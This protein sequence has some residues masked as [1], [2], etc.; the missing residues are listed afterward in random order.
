MTIISSQLNIPIRSTHYLNVLENPMDWFRVFNDGFMAHYETT[1]KLDWGLYVP[2]KNQMAPAGRG[3]LLS[4]SRLLVIS[5]AGVIHKDNDKPFACGNTLG[6]Y[7]I[8]LIPSD[9]VVEEL[10][11][12]E[13]CIPGDKDLFDINTLLPLPHL[14]AMVQ[15]GLVGSIAPVVISYCSHQPH[16]IRTVKEMIPVV[17]LAIRNYKAQ[18]VLILPI[19]WLGVQIAALLSR[20]IEANGTSSVLICSNDEIVKSIAPPRYLVTGSPQDSNTDLYMDTIDQRHVLESALNL[21]T[22]YAPVCQVYSSHNEQA[23]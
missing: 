1:G 21:L 17:E 7:S 8:R 3:V 23:N 13:G 10:S 5:G 15:E 20:A 6:D 19:D 12:S 2:P 18:A 9:A 22:Q 11:L 16:A 14:Q 4:D